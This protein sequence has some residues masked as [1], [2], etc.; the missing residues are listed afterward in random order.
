MINHD[1]PT[2]RIIITHHNEDGRSTIVY[3]LPGDTLSTD[4][5]DDNLEDGDLH[6]RQR[7][8]DSRWTDSIHFVA[9]SG[10]II[11]S[12][13]GTDVLRGSLTGDEWHAQAVAREI[14]KNTDCI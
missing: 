11:N 8:Y 14:I 12:A 5:W 3:E 2:E 9:K 1:L 4:G 13:F 10:E 7:Y 6:L